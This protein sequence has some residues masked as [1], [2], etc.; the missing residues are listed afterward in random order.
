MTDHDAFTVKLNELIEKNDAQLLRCDY[1]QKIFGNIAG[2][3]YVNFLKILRR[4][5][6]VCAAIFI[7]KDLRS[8][9]TFVDEW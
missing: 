9:V 6:S 2:L 4:R 1:F 3:E 7:I 5:L 8:N